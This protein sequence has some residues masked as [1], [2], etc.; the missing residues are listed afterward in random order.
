MFFVTL[1]A[2]SPA[3]LY[4]PWRVALTKCFIWSFT[5]T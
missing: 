2:G 3:S 5:K 4:L 1:S